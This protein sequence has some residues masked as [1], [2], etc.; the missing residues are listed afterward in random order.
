MPVLLCCTEWA[1]FYCLKS[2][3]AWLDSPVV[4]LLGFNPFSY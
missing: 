3:L 2:K 1:M 4:T